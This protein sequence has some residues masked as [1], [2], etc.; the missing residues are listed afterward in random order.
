VLVSDG[1]LSIGVY[2]DSADRVGNIPELVCWSSFDMLSIVKIVQMKNFV[3]D[4]IKV[5]ACIEYL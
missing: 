5:D 1:V 3:E 2:V 4:F